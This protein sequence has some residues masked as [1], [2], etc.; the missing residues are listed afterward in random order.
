MEVDFVVSG[1]D[2]DISEEDG[3]RRAIIA[4][5]EPLGLDVWAYVA[6]TAD[7]GLIG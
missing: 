1:A 3:V 4:A 5:L 2:W 7:P 6:L